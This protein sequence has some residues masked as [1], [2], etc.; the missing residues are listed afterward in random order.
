MS[1]ARLSPSSAHRWVS[2]PGSVKLSDGI[3]GTSS[4]HADEGTKAHE[5][6]ARV[7][8]AR[9]NG[10]VNE[11]SEN[12]FVQSYIDAVWRAAEGKML[13]IEHRLPVG[14]ITTEEGATGVSDAIIFDFDSGVLEVWDLKY[15]MG[16]IVHA[17]DNEQLMLYA[18]GAVQVISDIGGAVRSAKLVIFQPR[19]DHISETEIS[20]ATLAAFARRAK[21]SGLT[22]LSALAGMEEP[23]L[24]PSEKACQWCLA[25]T[26]CPALAATVHEAVAQDFLPEQGQQGVPSDD[27]L[28]MVEGWASAQRKAIFERLQNKVPTPGWKLVKG[29][30][31]NRTWINEKLVPKIL[32]QIGLKRKTTHE[33]K[34]LSLAKLEKIVPADKWKEL[35]EANITQPEGAPIAVADTDP[36]P[37]LVTASVEDF[38]VFK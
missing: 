19:R 34:L 14:F 4:V 30:R 28:S 23:T 5:E 24:R 8:L 31:G 35:L 3:P 27:Y 26:I 11:T 21:E 13:L 17:Q 22:A 6:A 32:K 33:T 29:K 7:L 1:H 9:Q 15:G 12:D 16:H 18:L 20:G 37:E 10:F 36:R 38:D 2:C 25:K